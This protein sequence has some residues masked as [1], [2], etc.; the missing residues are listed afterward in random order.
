MSIELKIKAASLAWESRYIRKQEIK[1]RNAG[2]T[3]ETFAIDCRDRRQSLYEHRIHVVRSTARWTHLARMFIKGTPYHM[4]EVNC[5]KAFNY[6]PVTA[7]I[8]RY[9]TPDM[10]NCEDKTLRAK[11]KLWLEKK[12]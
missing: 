8:K 2:R 4:V 10:R 7:M 11:I 9:G 1:Q 3:S 5:T 12:P 6:E